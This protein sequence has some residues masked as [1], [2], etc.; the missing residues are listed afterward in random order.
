MISDFSYFSAGQ[1]I[2][3]DVYVEKRPFLYYSITV[4]SCAD[5]QTCRFTERNFKS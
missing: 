1:M 4:K 3:V 2:V 5:D